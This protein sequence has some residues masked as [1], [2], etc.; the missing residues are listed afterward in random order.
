MKTD[1][2]GFSLFETLVCLLL[3]AV[4]LGLFS[5][6]FLNVSPKY[7]LE[8]AVWEIH[9]RLNYARYK[10]ILTGNKMK[11]RFT[12]PFINVERFE[13][14]QER[15]ILE[16]KNILEGVNLEANNSPIFHPGGTVSNLVSI[17]VYNS[18]GRYKITLAIT[19]RIKITPL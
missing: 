17:S 4:L 16:M 14:E 12:P 11:V 7:R 19:G 6:F 5:L 13:D 15:W 8:R 3:L 18:W 1:N 2:P 9:S 10:A